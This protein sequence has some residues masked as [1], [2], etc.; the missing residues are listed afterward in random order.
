MNWTEPDFGITTQNTSVQSIES[1]ITGFV[2][3]ADAKVWLREAQVKSAVNVDDLE[4]SETPESILLGV[5]SGDQSKDLKL[6]TR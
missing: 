5:V 6:S 4:A 1:V 2:S 3:L